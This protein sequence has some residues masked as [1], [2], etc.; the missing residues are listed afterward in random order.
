MLI[1][2]LAAQAAPIASAPAPVAAPAPARFSILEPIGTE[3]CVRRG[4][5][6]KDKTDPNDI[7]VCGK[8]IPLQK[9]PYPN[10]V[11]LDEP[12]PSNPDL[13]GTGALAAEGNGP[14]ASVQRGCSTGIDIFGGG[15]QVVR[16]IQKV[17]APDSCCERPGEASNFFMLAGDVA[18]G[19][20][21]AF[22]KK[23]DKSKRIAIA[24]DAPP[25]TGTIL[26]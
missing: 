9:L 24:L 5:D 3:P 2:L 14:C 22:R 6:G 11:V 25:P 4:K 15:T 7:V 1:L 18:K 21:K 20:G 12:R 19:V 26:P 8:P 16:M 13:R 23:P 10:E 17:I